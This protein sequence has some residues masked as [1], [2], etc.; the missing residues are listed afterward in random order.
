MGS[1]LY[2]CQFNSYQRWLSCGQTP[3]YQRNF[4]GDLG[5]G[6]AVVE[7]GKEE[8][9]SEASR[10]LDTRRFFFFQRVARS[11]PIFLWH[12]L[13]F[14]GTGTRLEGKGTLIVMSLQEDVCVWQTW[15]GYF[16]R[17]LS[18]PWPSITCVL[19]FH[20]KFC[21]TKRGEVWRYYYFFTSFIIV[22]FV[23]LVSR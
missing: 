15:R 10:V 23:T 4:P 8:S 14:V 1:R 2:F 12:W 16:L 7:K 17:V 13:I 6:S 20:K 18:W 19:V 9:S 11:Q 5:A 3:S 21:L 22:T